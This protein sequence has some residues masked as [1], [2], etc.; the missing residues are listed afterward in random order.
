MGVLTRGSV[1]KC[2]FCLEKICALSLQLRSHFHS[3]YSYVVASLY[4]YFPHF[5]MLITLVISQM[6]RRHRFDTSAFHCDNTHPRAPIAVT[7]WANRIKLDSRLCGKVTWEKIPRSQ[8]VGMGQEDG[9]SAQL[10][11][12]LVPELDQIVLASTWRSLTRLV[13]TV[14]REKGRVGELGGV[15]EGAPGDETVSVFIAT[16]FH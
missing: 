12:W 10:S 14:G 13:F 4:Y 1:G 7:L 16:F 9:I 15:L 8:G 11:V 5:Y 6:S 3:S 2:N